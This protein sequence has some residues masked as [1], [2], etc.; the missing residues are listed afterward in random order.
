[1]LEDSMRGLIFKVSLGAFLGLALWAL[2]LSAWA[3]DPGRCIICGMD[4]TQYPHSRYV[5]ATT[6]GKTHVTCGVQ[7]GLTLH[8]RLK[9]KWASASAT[10][11]LSN[12]VFDARKGFYVFKSSV[13]TDMAPGFIA[14]KQ[15]GHAD[16][17]AK[18]F[19][20]Q[21]VSYDEALELWGKQMN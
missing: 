18:G 9:E 6:D 8:L 13:I 17:F 7:C 1:M 4:N 19:G 3:D 16:K 10:D 11:L 14:F 21:V 5:V 20:G 12:R 2:T 15:K